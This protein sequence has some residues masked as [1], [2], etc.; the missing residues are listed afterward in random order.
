MLSVYRAF[1][2][3]LPDG[4]GQPIAPDW[5]Q[6]DPDRYLRGLLQHGEAVSGEL[7]PL[8]LVYFRIGGVVRHAGVMVDTQRFIHVLEHR[9]VM[10]TRLGS[11]WSRRLA[12][13][14]RIV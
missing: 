11:W 5:W 9:P 8:D 14:R 6:R 13:A 2:I 1:G 3:A 7:R 10:V 4:D 12:G